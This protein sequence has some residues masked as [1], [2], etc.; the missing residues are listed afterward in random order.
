MPTLKAQLQQVIANR[1][2]VNELLSRAES[3][4]N[5][6]DWEGDAGDNREY[7]Q[8]A[9]SNILGAKQLDP[10]YPAINQ[11][12]LALEQKY[13]E[14]IRV[15]YEA[16]LFT[17]GTLLFEQASETELPTEKIAAQ[18]KILDDRKSEYDKKNK[19][20]NLTRQMGIF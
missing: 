9:Y 3:S 1:A 6:L 7:L 5:R 13:A 18:K 2:Q 19:K 8:Q 15:Y 11:S 17:K 12:L 4:F 16:S 14:G 20:K 10:G